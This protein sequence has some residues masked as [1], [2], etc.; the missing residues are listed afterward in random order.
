MPRI[1]P[2]LILSMWLLQS[3][4]KEDKPYEFE[5]NADFDFESEQL[6]LLDWEGN[7]TD[8][9]PEQ[10]ELMEFEFGRERLPVPYATRHGLRFQG[11]NRSDDM[12]MY[13]VRMFTGLPP[14]GMFEV[15]IELEIASQYPENSV[16]IGGSPGS[17]VF[18]KA[19]AVNFAP[20][21]ILSNNYYSINVDK[22][23][24]SQGGADMQVLGHIG[25]TAQLGQW[26][27]INRNNLNTP[28]RV[29][30]NPQGL[31]WVIIGIDSGFEGLT[32]LYYDRIKVKMKMVE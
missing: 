22:G 26:R 14:G 30:S 25:T 21:K 17:S 2:L 32:E 4:F 7:Y 28:L 16:G 12:F 31:L 20:Q 11:H 6:G 18:V 1:L 15:S 3:C 29:R 5:L 13:A 10:E 8:Y 19:G 24:Q 23:N 27:I 9:A